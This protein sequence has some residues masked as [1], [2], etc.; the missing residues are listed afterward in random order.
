ML[1]FSPGCSQYKLCLKTVAVFNIQIL[2]NS[3]FLDLDLTIYVEIVEIILK[4]YFIQHIRYIEPVMVVVHQYE[5]NAIIKKPSSWIVNIKI[6]CSDSV[7]CLGFSQSMI[8]EF[9]YMYVYM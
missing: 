2:A 5:I 6:F 3:S 1:I 8:N 7:H 9:N 4:D